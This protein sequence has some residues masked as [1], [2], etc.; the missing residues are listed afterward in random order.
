MILRLRAQ[1][2]D[3]LTCV[4]HCDHGIGLVYKARNQSGL[5][6]TLAQIDAMAYTDH[7]RDAK[8]LLDLRK[9]K[10]LVLENSG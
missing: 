10:Y 4:L 3:L 8:R 6:L 5:S 9:P 2:M 7:A 1:H